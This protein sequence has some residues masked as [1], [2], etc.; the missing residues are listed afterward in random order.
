MLEPGPEQR[1]A[2]VALLL[3][4][5]DGVPTYA[6]T[7]RAMTLR[8][9]AGNFA[10]PGGH[11]DPGEDAIDAA[12]R[13]TWEELGVQL[14]RD[15]CLG[16]LDDFTTLGG[17]RVTPVVL[18]SPE[19]LALNP[20]P[21][22]V[23]LAWLEPLT[24]LD[25]PEAPKREPHPDGGGDI[26]RMFVRGHWINPPTAAFLYQFREVALHGRPARVHAV[27]QPSWTAR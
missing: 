26:L 1:L 15:H 14:T 10:L 23:H 22:E 21:D 18:W 17:Q 12:L 4:P 20:N 19:P 25:H 2:A 16:L 11:I 3:S 8:R 9:G 13:E 5:L 6:I 27:G 24:D 7:R